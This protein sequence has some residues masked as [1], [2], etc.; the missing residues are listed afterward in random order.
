MINSWNIRKQKR[1]NQNNKKKKE[2]RKIRVVSI[3]SL[4]D[5]FKHSNIH[6][7]GV[8]KEEKEQEIEN[9]FEKIIKEN[10]PNLAK[11]IDIQIREAQRVPNKLDLKKT[12]P[13]YIINKISDVKIERI[14]KAARENRVLPTEKFP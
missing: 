12:I 1:T 6:I 3:S 2:S 4:W 5:N 14:L 11:E 10:F 13:R 7:I 8:P 9:L